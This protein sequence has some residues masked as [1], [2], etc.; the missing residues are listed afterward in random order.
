MGSGE[1]TVGFADGDAEAGHP[2]VL[3]KHELQDV[4][5]QGQERHSLYQL[6]LVHEKLAE[7]EKRSGSLE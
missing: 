6:H 2:L 3:P 7:I 1:E 4:H 5:G